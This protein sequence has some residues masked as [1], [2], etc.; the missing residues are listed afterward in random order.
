VVDWLW[1]AAGNL[2]LDLSGQG[3]QL[4]DALLHILSGAPGGALPC[5]T[6]YRRLRVSAKQLEEAAG[7]LM[8]L[9][10]IRK[11]RQHGKKKEV[12]VYIY[13]GGEML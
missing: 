1:A 2:F 9:G 11:I 4:E 10:L 12:D 7:G 13:T 8:K 6:L 5:R 3:R